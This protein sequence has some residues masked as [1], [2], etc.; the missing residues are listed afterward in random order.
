MGI[1]R[2][3]FKFHSPAGAD[4]RLC[5]LIFHRVL[6]QP[7]PL[8][9]N[10]MH[11]ARF[12]ALCGWLK[13]WFNVLPLNEAVNQ[14][15]TGTL[16][17][18]AACITFDDGYADNATVA[19][20]ILRRH[21]MTAT[22]FVATSFLDGGRMWNDTV[23]ESIR[24][25]A[26]DRLDLQ[27]NG[28]GEFGLNSLDERRTAIDQLL[29]QIKYLELDE[30]QATVDLVQR[31]A[32]STV[33]DDLMMT[34]AQVKQLQREGM[35]VGAHTCSHPILA[36]LPDDAAKLELSRSKSFL[37]SLIEAPVDLFAYPNG[38]PGQDYLHR[39]A[40]MARESGFSGAVSTAH[41]VSSSLT[42]PFQLARFSPWDKSRYRYGAR[43]LLNLRHGEPEL[44]DEIA[45]LP[46]A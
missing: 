20:P 18:R 40:L 9:P 34:S 4:A 19:M 42:D 38:K 26:A 6:P 7:D 44:A 30:R 28:L 32:G 8:F 10:E 5:T 24:N 41:G 12:D 31:A 27:A 11:A 14:L 43:L 35:Q 36:R 3:L 23:I 2:T 29:G 1:L 46:A 16:P 45:Y 33:A 25:C 13:S 39:H 15:A 22:F 21:G 37:E 17:E